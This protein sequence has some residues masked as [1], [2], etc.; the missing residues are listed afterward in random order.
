MIDFIQNKKALPKSPKPKKAKQ[1]SWLRGLLH[2]VNN[3]ETVESSTID[4]LAVAKKEMQTSAA[5][6][7]T[8][9]TD[10]KQ[11]VSP[12]LQRGW[13]KTKPTKVKQNISKKKPIFSFN[14]SKSG[15]KINKKLSSEGSAKVRQGFDVN[16][17]PITARFKSTNKIVVLLLL[18]I[19]MTVGIL[20]V[21]FIGISFYGQQITE[22]GL[23]LETE[24][25]FLDTEI[26][27]YNSKVA[28]AAEWQ[29]KLSAIDTLL[30]THVYWTNFFSV[31]E[32]TTLPTVYYNGF[33]ASLVNS[34]INLVSYA[35]NFSTVAKQ[36]IAYE[37]FPEVFSKFGVAEAS[38]DEGVGINYNALVTLQRSLFYDK[39]FLKQIKK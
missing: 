28:T 36:L 16:L 27:K 22:E 11:L 21:I 23:A 7:S 37:K 18:W 12:K 8:I 34:N 24:I 3:K 20:I 2:S 39:S 17:L 35:K 25:E 38:L 32:Q 14:Q 31:L 9:K 15:D 30:K 10:K 1:S 29:I 6:L 4:L 26:V 19:S 13:L 5:K 33:T